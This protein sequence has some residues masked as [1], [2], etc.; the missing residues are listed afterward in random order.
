MTVVALEQVRKV[1]K[2][3]AV[4][5]EALKGV[6]LQIR[7]GEM[8]ALMGPSG[9]GK[10]TLMQ[11]IGLLDRPT[12]GRYLLAGRDVTTLSENERA[13]VRNQE[14]G[15]VF[16]A[17]HLLPRLNVLENVEVPLIYAGY[18]PQERRARAIEVLQKVGLGDKLKNLPSQL[19]G[20]QKQRVAIARALAMRPSILLADEPTGNLDSKTAVEVMRLFQELNEEGTCVVIVTH[21]PDIAE[22]TER[23]V[24]IRDGQVESDAPNPYRKR[25]VGGLA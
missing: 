15:F 12:E 2:S 6:S 19:S 7:Q 21:E 13:E 11:I 16:Q 23:I 9:S 20:G 25:A 5:F 1:Y 22:Y 8:V 18:S 24:R 3:G 4:E 17:F 14:I 10:T